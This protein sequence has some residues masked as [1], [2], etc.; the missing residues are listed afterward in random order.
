MKSEADLKNEVLL[1]VKPATLAMWEI[2]SAVVSCLVAEWVF[3]S[4]VGTS[5]VALAVPVTL[6]VFLMVSSHRIY[7]ETPGQIGFRI[8]NLFAALRLLI[9]PTAIAVI[10]V[11][12]LGWLLSYPTFT[13]RSL[14]FR[15]LLTAPWALFQQYALQGYINRRAQVWLGQGWRSILLVA[16]IFSLVHFPNPIL[17]ALTLAGGLVWASVYQ[18]QP[19]LFALAVSH[20]ISSIA[21][22]IFIPQQV[23]SSLRVGFKF[24]G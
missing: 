15:F 4:F 9:L 14:R 7:G 5:K 17:A 6:A 24:F 21:V 23:V 8:D 19:N 18:R 22:A 3:M 1:S 12:A 20:A 2:F 11:F 10:I 13:A 16:A